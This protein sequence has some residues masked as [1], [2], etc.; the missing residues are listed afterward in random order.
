MIA[1]S[2][3]DNA[4][5]LWKRDATLLKNLSHSRPVN[6]VSFSPDGKMIL[7]VTTNNNESTI[8][9]WNSNGTEIKTF[10]GSTFSFSAS[11][12]ADSKIV[13]VNDSNVLKLYIPNGFW[14]KE[15]PIEGF[16]I[17]SQLSFSPDGKALAIASEDGVSVLSLEPDK[18]IKYGCKWAH[19]YLKNNPKA[20]SDRTLCDDIK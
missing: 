9:L 1:S 7:S 11:F 2:G 18:L 16:N 10:Q 17:V 12:S 19:D 4:V 14:V 20:K 3:E 5:K 8:V 6:T 13:A 15:I